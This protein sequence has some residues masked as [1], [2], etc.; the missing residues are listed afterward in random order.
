MPIISILIPAYNVEPYLRRCLD[1]VIGQAFPDMEIIIV[2]DGSTDGTGAILAEYSAKDP[3]IRVI[4]HPGN[5]GL[6]WARK[7]AIEASSGSY[8]MFV[9]SDDELMPGACDKLYSEAVRTGA[10][11]V[12]GEHDYIELSGRVYRKTNELK[13]GSSAYGVIKAMAMDDLNRYMWGKLYDRELFTGHPVTFLMHHNVGE[14]Q[15]I[16]Y[17]ITRYVRKAVIIC[18]CVYRYYQN[19]TSLINNVRS[20]K[21]LHDAFVTNRE[22]MGIA[23]QI[24]DELLKIT[25]TNAMRLFF[26]FIKKGQGR[27]RVMGFVEEFGFSE[28]FRFPSLVSHFGV[29]KA[30][31]YFAVTRFGFVSRLLYGRRWKNVSHA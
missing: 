4:D 29:R 8:L 13:Y 28:L 24:D 5:C 14:D 2:N 16:S 18:D 15:I 26:N 21:A 1:S 6:M 19:S 27:K 7:T 23:R 25:E 12:I 22:T 9:D 31:I 3:R 30:L 20:D 17:Q 10:D 11:L